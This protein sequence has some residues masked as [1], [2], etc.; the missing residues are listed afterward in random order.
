MSKATQ[1]AA[2]SKLPKTLPKV[3]VF[4]LDGCCWQPEMFELWSHRSASPFKSTDGGKTAQTSDGRPVNLI[5]HVR[6]ILEHLMEHPEVENGN[7]K[8]ALASTCDEP[9]WARELLRVFKLTH[10]KTKKEIPMGD[11]FHA[12]EIYKAHNK[13][14]HFHAIKKKLSGDQQQIEF[15]E[16]AFFD[17]Q[18]NNIRDVGK[19]GVNA[20]LTPDGVM[21][22]HWVQHFG[23]KPEWASRL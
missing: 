4:D 5:G 23:P 8:L 21:W 3:L 9:D 11:L 13:H 7:T 2:N 20:I 19:L 1:S 18:H 14:P 22:E 16:M 10:P 12:H 6:Q 17:N 15:H